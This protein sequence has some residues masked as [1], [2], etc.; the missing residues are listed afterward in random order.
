MA[1]VRLALVAAVCLASVS[2]AGPTARPV[3]EAPEHAAAGL[4]NA[5]RYSAALEALRARAADASD[6]V[7]Q[8][9]VLAWRAR[10]EVDRGDFAAAEATLARAAPRAE[11]CGDLDARARVHF[12]RGLLFERRQTSGVGGDPGFSR[13]RA[14]YAA[15]HALATEA[16]LS[17]LAL[18]H[19]RIGVV[20]ERTGDDAQADRTYQ[21]V[22]VETRRRDDA[23]AEAYAEL[24]RA[25]IAW[26]AGQ[27]GQVRAGQERALAAASRAGVAF[28]EAAARLNLADLESG[29]AGARTALEV[30]EQLAP[31]LQHLP[32]QMDSA[33]VSALETAG[34]LTQ[35]HDPASA[36][37]LLRRA[38]AQAERSG[39]VKAAEGLR[40]ALTAPAPPF[41]SYAYG[42]CHESSGSA[43]S[44]P[45]STTAARPARVGGRRPKRT[46]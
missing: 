9:R 36:Q 20:A 15:A 3:P 44:M 39:L 33:Y 4:A 2:C 25:N 42:W 45:A 14:E 34:A 22:L 46:R 18:A 12:A 19:F 26:R 43:G 6:P 41:S 1:A 10:I 23:E 24:H 8:A 40:E 21:Q 7:A 31:R 37:A 35:P 17:W 28:V 13:A 38:L 30:A 5:G 29:K 27:L 16:S 11:A 32:G